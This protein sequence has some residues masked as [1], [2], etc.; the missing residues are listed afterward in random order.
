MTWVI[1]AAVL[2]V[3]AV[4]L[5]T[6]RQG[7]EGGGG[8]PTQAVDAADPQPDARHDFRLEYRDSGHY[9]QGYIIVRNRD[10]EVFRWR[11]PE[12]S[13]G[14]IQ[15]G[16]AGELDHKENLQSPDF[17]PGRWLSLVREPDSHHDREGHATAITNADETMKVGHVPSDRAE[18]VARMLD[19]GAELRCLSVWEVVQIDERVSLRVLLIGPEASIDLGAVS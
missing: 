8:K 2:V 7:G 12:G 18:E 19:D 16:V 5:W 9:G 4:V 6:V 14:L 3:G 15:L 10:G 17:D 11:T 13:E 1:M